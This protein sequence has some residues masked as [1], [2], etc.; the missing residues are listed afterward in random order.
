MRMIPP[1]YA[2]F[3]HL[4]VVSKKPLDRLLDDLRAAC[5]AAGM[6]IASVTS[7]TAG[8]GGSLPPGARGSFVVELDDP[9]PEVKRDDDAR[10]LSTYKVAGYESKDG[11]TRLSTMR[12]TRLVDL[13]GHPEHSEAAAALERRLETLLSAAAGESPAG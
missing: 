1:P 3:V 9:L 10:A 7:Q 12:P 13:L 4:S 11:G 5:S 8:P 6:S 2:S